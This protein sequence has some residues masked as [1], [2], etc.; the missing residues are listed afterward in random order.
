MIKAS[1]PPGVRD[2]SRAGRPHRL[3]TDGP[4]SGTPRH[5]STARRRF[6]VTTMQHPTSSPGAAQSAH[7][8]S[9]EQR[10]EFWAHV[11][12]A[13]PQAPWIKKRP[14]RL[15]Y[16][17]DNVVVRATHPGG[18]SITGTVYAHDLSAGGMSF[19][20]Q[21]YLHVGTTLSVTLPRRLTGEETVD[22]KVARCQHV[23][24]T[25]HA[26][27]V[28]FNAPVSVKMFV[29]PTEWEHLPTGNPIRPES[30]TGQV[31][32]I[33]DQELDRLLFAHMLR[34]TRL[35]VTGVADID[36]AVMALRGLVFDV[37]C[38]DLTL[39]VGKA[40]GEDVIEAVRSAG[41]R[42]PIAVI[43]GEPSNRLDAVRAMNIE[44]ALAKPYDA[45]Q[46]FALLAG[47]LGVGGTDPA[48]LL[49]S[50]L[51]DQEGYGEL[52][53]KF[54]DRVQGAMREFR[55]H[56][57]ANQ[58][59]EVVLTCQT[60]RG[61]AGGFGYPAVAAAATSAIKAINACGDVGEA[62]ADLQKLVAV[63]KRLTAEKRPPAEA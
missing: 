63:C 12:D 10:R 20:Y 15:A 22:G 19:L 61:S 35:K 16:N 44:H 13:D 52:L 27:G 55:R 47:A 39:G 43:S 17:Q 14:P 42:G 6:T 49:Y 58:L 9:D 37:V 53:Q 8:L 48:D 38:V 34:A 11:E 28:K 51:A 41:H 2:V 24:G 29:S 56:V 26:V 3:P 4:G 5:R 46:L 25:W 36:Q 32:M 7:G 33:D 54:C 45:E 40:R 21:G 23:G 60:L 62:T 18:G 50:D 30:L 31:L 1:T 57:D 59:D